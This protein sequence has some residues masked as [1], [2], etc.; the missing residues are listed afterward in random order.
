MPSLSKDKRIIL[1]QN[2]ST[3]PYDSTRHRVEGYLRDQGY[4]IK[5]FI[6][7][8]AEI[9]NLD[10]EPYLVL[11]IG[12]DGSL[13]KAIR[14]FPN[15]PYVIGINTGHLGFL[16][17][18]DSENVE[19]YLEALVNGDWY[20]N[21]RS[22]ISLMHPDLSSSVEALNDIVIKSINP[23]RMVKIN[24]YLICEDGS[25]EEFADYDAD[26]LI[27]A[28]PT[29]STAYNMG[30]GGSI[31]DPNTKVIAVTPICPH[32][33]SAKPIIISPKYPIVIESD[34]ANEEDLIISLDGDDQGFIKP[35]NQIIIED[36]GKT[37]QLVRFPT[38]NKGNY[39]SLLK[40]KLG[41]NI[42]LRAA[43]VRN[44]SKI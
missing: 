26:G 4:D 2:Q 38:L 29:G 37:Y 12:G 41:W 8:A 35:G 32:S 40:K 13:L 22:K 1:V 3:D 39:Y 15:S 44:R 28:T 6:C 9:P 24:T 31:I 42:N 25:I 21:E 18:I 27:I 7:K 5:T 17:S 16:T 30:A 34:S 23:S 36:L 10:Y 43:A 11:V 19:P 20:S 14:R 33:L